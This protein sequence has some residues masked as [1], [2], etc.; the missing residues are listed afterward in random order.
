MM[1]GLRCLERMGRLLGTENLIYRCAVRGINEG[2]NTDIEAAFTDERV[3][4]CFT[5]EALIQ[6]LKAGAYVSPTDVRMHFKCPH[7]RDIVLD[8]CEKHGIG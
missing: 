7:F 8:C 5:A 6:S 4:E 1:E 3:F 2:M